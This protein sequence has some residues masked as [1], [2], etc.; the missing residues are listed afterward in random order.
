ME[1]PKSS[2]DATESRCHLRMRVLLAALL[3]LFGMSIHGS[4]L[5]TSVQV[6]ARMNLHTLIGCC[7]CF[8]DHGGQMRIV[9]LSARSLG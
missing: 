3:W 9:Q 6:T 5:G 2:V 4:Y 8:A 7:L 1:G